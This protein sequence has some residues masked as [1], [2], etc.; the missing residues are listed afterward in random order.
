MSDKPSFF[1][2]LRR[3]NVYKVAVAYPAVLGALGHAYAMADR[4][5]DARTVLDKLIT[6]SEQRYVPA[7][8][9]A[10]IHLAL[11]D[12]DEALR[13]L[14]KSYLEGA[15]NLKNVKRDRKLDPLRGDPRFEALVKRVLSG[16]RQ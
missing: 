7:Y 1:G 8:S 6:L 10:V 5:E 3:R 9:L 13:L 12:T 16:E 4:E 11:G 2:E 14:E 15:S